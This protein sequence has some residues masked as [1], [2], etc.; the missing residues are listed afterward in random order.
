[1]KRKMNRQNRQY[2][3]GIVGVKNIKGKL[4]KEVLEKMKINF[5]DF[6]LY[7]PGIG[8]YALFDSFRDE[9]KLVRRPEKRELEK[10]DVVFFTLPVEDELFFAPRVSVDLSGSRKD[11]VKIVSSI[12]DDKIDSYRIANPSPATIGLSYIIHPFSE[13]I[14]YGFSTVIEPV[15]EYGEEAM[16]ELF[17]QAV[18]LLN[19]EEIP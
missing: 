1:M 13:K 11:I 16:D 15:S 8:E 7:E 14:E 6:Y 3:A 5:K 4:I 18:N 12:N 2:R 10:L 19:M 9:A 17:S